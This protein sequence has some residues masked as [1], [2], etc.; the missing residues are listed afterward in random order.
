[1]SRSCCRHDHRFGAGARKLDSPIERLS[2]NG[3]IYTSD[4]TRT[5]GA[6]I[7]F[8]MCMRAVQA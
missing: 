7:G 2:D 3:S 1:M 8:V 5:F 6:E 4:E